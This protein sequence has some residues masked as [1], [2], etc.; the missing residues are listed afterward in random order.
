MYSETSLERPPHW[1]Q[2]CGLSRQVVSGDRFSC[3][4]MYVHLPKM[5]GQSRQVV[6]HGSGLSRE[7][8]LYIL[9]R[10]YSQD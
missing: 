6:S 9:T 4:E 3:I 8:P 7:V 1:P 5:R 2:K 10:Q